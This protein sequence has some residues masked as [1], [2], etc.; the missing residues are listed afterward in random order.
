[1]VMSGAE[2]AEAIPRVIGVEPALT[3][4]THVRNREEVERG[5]S[6]DLGRLHSWRE[7]GMNKCFLQSIPRL[8]RLIDQTTMNK[9]Q[10]LQ[11]SALVNC[12]RK[13]N[14]NSPPVCMK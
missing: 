4:P 13:Q 12:N 7:L 14:R 8:Y 10:N 6:I 3:G 2:G 1:M 9:N 11:N 5:K